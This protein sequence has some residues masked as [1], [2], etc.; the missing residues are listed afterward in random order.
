M[1][2]LVLKSFEVLMSRYMNFS[3]HLFLL[4]VVSALLNCAGKPGVKTAQN[5]LDIGSRNIQIDSTLIADPLLESFILPFR[6]E[7]NKTMNVVI[8]HA[9]VDLTRGKPEATLNNFV[10]DLMLKRANMEFDKPVEIA[11]TNLGGLRVDIPKGP[12]TVGKIYEVMPFENELVILEMT[13][14]QLISLVQEIGELGGEPISGMRMEFQSGRLRKLTVGDSS[15]ENDKIY[16]LT[17]TDYLSSPGRKREKI[18]SQVP[19]TFLGVTLRDAILNEIESLQKEGKEI[20]AKT[21]GRI[22]FDEN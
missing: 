13:G 3:K 10:A 7:L 15:V 22:I 5:I 4:I 19:R 2:T 21:D 14:K 8:G 17:T 9:G 12:I 6:T 20:T 11:L 16:Y 18:L 1:R